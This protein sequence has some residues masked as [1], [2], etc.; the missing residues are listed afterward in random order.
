LE[1]VSDFELIKYY[2]TSDVHPARKNEKWLNACLR[3]PAGAMDLNFFLTN[4]LVR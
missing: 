3:A 1:Q 4:T 2:R